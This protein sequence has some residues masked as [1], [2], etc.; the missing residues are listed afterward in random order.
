MW[1][2]LEY[3]CCWT[4]LLWIKC[5]LILQFHVSLNSQVENC[6]SD[7]LIFLLLFL[8][9]RKVFLLSCMLCPTPSYWSVSFSIGFL[10]VSCCFL[11]SYLKGGFRP[12]QV[13]HYWFCMASLLLYPLSIIIRV[14]L[15]VCWWIHAFMV[16]ICYWYIVSRLLSLQW[17][18]EIT[19]DTGCRL[20]HLSSA[21]SRP[22]SI[23]SRFSTF[24]ANYLRKQNWVQ[25]SMKLPLFWKCFSHH[26]TI[27]I[28]QLYR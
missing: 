25:F 4:Y 7:F 28:W 13:T 1:L 18:P 24:I 17:E 12:I 10:S 6:H 9:N 22:F 11:A 5:H 14:R 3:F 2:L 26:V 8:L 20:R 21:S 15:I 16:G 23:L 27:S 19:T